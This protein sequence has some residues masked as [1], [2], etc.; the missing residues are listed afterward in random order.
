[1]KQIV[2]LDCILT[3]EKGF[4]KTIGRVINVGG[5]KK[6]EDN[7]CRAGNWQVKTHTIG[8]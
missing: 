8:W 1:M 7:K 4:F 6:F 5:G 3:T 2:L